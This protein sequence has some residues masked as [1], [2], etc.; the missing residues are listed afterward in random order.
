MAPS[1]HIR[2]VTTTCSSGC[3]A[4]DALFWPP[5]AT[6]L[7][8]D[9]LVCR[10]IFVHIHKNKLSK[11]RHRNGELHLLKSSLSS[12]HPLSSL[13]TSHSVYSLEQWFSAFLMLKPFN[14]G[15]IGRL[16]KTRCRRGHNKQLE[17]HYSIRCPTRGWEGLYKMAQASLQIEDVGLGQK[18]LAIQIPKA[19]S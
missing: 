6:T 17:N 18:G 14:I 12:F 19:W 9:I 7:H 15:R 1:T 8:K 16:S 11:A 4:S 13:P 10:C 2:Q 5:P 3:R